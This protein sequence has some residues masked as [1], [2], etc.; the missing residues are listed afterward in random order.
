M[1]D[2]QL[3]NNYKSFVRGK[4]IFVSTI[5]I[6]LLLFVVLGITQ[7]PVRISIKDIL[8]ILFLGNES[9]NSNIVMNI[10]LPRVLSAAIAGT[11]LSISGA[12]MQTLLR[13]PLASPVSLGISHGAAFGAAFA[14]V[15]LGAGTNHSLQADA[16]LVTNPYLV[17]ISAFAWS[18]M[19]TFFILLISKVKSSSTEAIILAGIVIGSLFT[20][21]TSA[22]QYFADDVQL[23]SIVFW[24]FGDLGRASWK[25]FIFLSVTV[26]PVVIYFL[27]NRWNL[28]ILS[29]GDETAS[30][31]GVNVNRTRFVGMILASL[32]TA[33]AV[34]FF[35][36]IAFV[37][38]VVPHIVKRF[39]GHD[40]RFMIPAT[41]IFGAL[42]LL[43]SDTL[44]RTIFSPIILPVGILTSFM[45]APLFIW[46]LV[47]K[48][49]RYI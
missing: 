11:A 27:R 15:V 22:L 12:A 37:G 16:V 36:V 3:H 21:G 19:G 9:Q 23:S 25:D 18:L 40:E 24:M 7:G 43:V 1:T 28:N 42:F 38:L 4:I 33:M 26:V 13:N 32:L 48:S 44:A 46:L 47:R 31:L 8:G 29:T 14:I 39:I 2:N 6:I 41:A 5:A 20:A 30:S 10:R 49:G 34:S 45:G 17:T 35:G